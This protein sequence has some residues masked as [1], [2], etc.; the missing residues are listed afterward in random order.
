M[1]STG[2]ISNRTTSEVQF[3]IGYVNIDGS[4]SV[5]GNT[6][7]LNTGGGQP[8]VLCIDNLEMYC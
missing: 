6:T 7:K 1:Y 2:R 5:S 8:V 3:D 4:G